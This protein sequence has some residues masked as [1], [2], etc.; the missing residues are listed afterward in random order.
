M[1]LYEL[2]DAYTSALE[3][4]SDPE[5]SFNDDLI[6]DTLESIEL[7][8]DDKVIQAACVIKTMQAEAEAIRAAIAPMLARQKA[9]EN[10][11]DGVKDYLLHNMK[12]V[13]KKQVKSPWLTV[14]LQASP[15]ALNIFDESKIPDNFKHEVV[16]VITD[17]ALIKSLIIAGSHVEGC[18]VVQGSHLRIK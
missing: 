15:K 2:S 18:E 5:E 10:R 17:K 12:K 1:K 13:G 9:L 3:L 16:T 11:V 6:A 7:D 14:K 4:F 8:F